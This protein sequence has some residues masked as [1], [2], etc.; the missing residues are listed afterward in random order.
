MAIGSSFGAF[1]MVAGVWTLAA[2]VS[3][4]I[5]PG[6]RKLARFRS[7]SVCLTMAVLSATAAVVVRHAFDAA[8]AAR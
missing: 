2:A 3:F 5:G 8:R 6:E 4:A 1:L 7:L